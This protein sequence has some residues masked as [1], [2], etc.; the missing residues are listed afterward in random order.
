M[1]TERK[2]RDAEAV[3]S[4]PIF[5]WDHRVRGPGVKITPAGTGSYVLNYRVGGRER[6]ATLAR[7]PEIGLRDARGRAGR[8]LTAIRNGGTRGVFDTGAH[9][10]AFGAK[11]APWTGPG[12]FPG[13]HPLPGA[14]PNAP[15]RGG[16]S[17]RPHRRNVR[18]A[19]RRLPPMAALRCARDCSRPIAE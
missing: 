3:N 17:S 9:A 15:E 16:L 12:S 4:K 7:C 18:T 13:V 8:E 1:P 5:L 19:G 6:R 11:R 10:G 14:F 2:T